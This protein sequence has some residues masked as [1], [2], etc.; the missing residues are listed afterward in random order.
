MKVLVLAYDFP[1]LISIGAQRPYSWLKYLPAAGIEVTVVTRHWSEKTSS[2]VDYV[3]PTKSEIT[4]E[5]FATGATIIRAPFKPNLRDKLL[6]R[7]GFDKYVLLRKLL[8]FAYAFL[9]H[10]SFAFDA[11]REIYN[12]AEAEIL[13]NRPDVIIATGE[14]FLLFKYAHS[15]SAKHNIPW[16]ADYRDGWTSNQGNYQLGFLTRLQNNFYRNRELKYVSN[17]TFITTASPTYVPSLNQIHPD[18]RVFVVYNGFDEEYF[19][20]LDKISAPENKFVISY[21]GTI[22]PHQQLEMFLEGLSQFVSEQKIEPG[23]LEVHFYG[24]DAQP[25]AKSR[26]LSYNSSLNKFLFSFP[27]IPYAQLIREM[28]ASHLLLL[29]SRKDAHW[30]N[31]KV[32]DYL[33]VQRPILLVE[34]DHGI[35]EQTIKET[36]SGLAANSTSETAQILARAYQKFKAGQK[37]EV[38]IDLQ[39]YS[40]K[41]QALEL[42]SLLKKEWSI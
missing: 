17:A 20:G 6:L 10:L 25:A 13:K 1:P 26:V 29:L 23:K 42:A 15:L 28:R 3:K 31:A 38:K 9:K 8:T 34:N 18:K 41:T 14:P 24:L 37:E 27:R 35:L 16:I 7:F 30:L 36:N 39:R 40:R 32:F 12:A 4:R 19:N 5:N 21:S 2:P 33:G 11:K 22:Y